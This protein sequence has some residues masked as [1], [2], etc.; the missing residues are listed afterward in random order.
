VTG[1]IQ[2]FDGVPLRVD[3]EEPLARDVDI[4]ERA[5]M[6][7]PRDVRKTIA[8]M[9]AEGALKKADR[10]AATADRGV[11][12]EPVVVV[13]TAFVVGGN[14]AKTPVVEYWLNDIAASLLLQR[15]RTKPA[16]AFSLKLAQVF[17]LARLGKLPAPAPTP[18]PQPVALLPVQAVACLEAVRLLSEPNVMALFG[19]DLA[20]T[21][22]EHYLAE[23]TGKEPQAVAPRMLT[24]EDY[25]RQR[26]MSA[27]E[28]GAQASAFGK[29][30]KAAYL[31]RHG[32]APPQVDRFVQGAVRAVC[33]YTETDRALFDEAFGLLVTTRSV[34]GVTK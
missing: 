1:A 5:E 29:L 17:K 28:A 24:A 18:P 25:L 9:L 4:S 7:R 14:G 16:Q 27:K 3:G 30:V 10:N 34:G 19:A 12:L 15:L 21:K 32:E 31:R 8:A 22:A 26:G 33:G 23:A 2:V 11:V 13:E 6:P 20:R